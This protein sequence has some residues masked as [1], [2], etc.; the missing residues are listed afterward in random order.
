MATS[1]KKRS[2]KPRAPREDGR[3]QFLS[4]LPPKLVADLKIE[5]IHRRTPAYLIVEE[6]LT[7]W[8]D[9]RSKKN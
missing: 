8:L 1:G 4:Y 5:A 3:Q 7:E 2:R 9:G 6:A